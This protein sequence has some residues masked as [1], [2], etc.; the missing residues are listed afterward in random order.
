[1]ISRTTRDAYSDSG[2]AGEQRLVGEIRRVNVHEHQPGRRDVPNGVR[3]AVANDLSQ[4]VQAAQSL[5]G[6]EQIARAAQGRLFVPNQSLV[7]EQGPARP[8]DN[9]LVGNPNAL[10]R[11][12]ETRLEA[13]PIPQL[14]AASAVVLQSL[15]AH[16]GHLVQPDRSRH[17]VLQL[18]GLDRLDEV[19]QCPVLHRLDG[20]LHG[21]QAGHD[22]YG[23]VQ[24]VFANGAE[25]LQA[26]HPRH[27]DVADDDVEGPR[28][29][30]R[31][32]LVAV[33]S[34]LNG[35]PGRGQGSRVA[36]GDGR[37]V[38]HEQNDASRRRCLHMTRVHRIG[39][40]TQRDSH[41]FLSHRLL[42]RID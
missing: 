22:D 38:I 2:D 31:G 7:G 40:E 24:I 11:A 1:M 34:H 18:S 28:P 41:R 8:R 9:R 3:D 21:R 23:H 10:E 13:G 5:G 26:T 25:Q 16:A 30:Q 29:E 15:A 36:P 37:L 6:V 20:A 27:R 32:G 12:C 33:V 17:H 14:P 19:A 42:V 4:L 35:I 39:L